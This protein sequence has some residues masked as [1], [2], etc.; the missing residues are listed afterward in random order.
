MLAPSGMLQISSMDRCVL[1]K[2]TLILLHSHFANHIQMRCSTLYNCA[3]HICPANTDKYHYAPWKLNGK[4]RFNLY[5]IDWQFS[6]VTWRYTAGLTKRMKTEVFSSKWLISMSPTL[7]HIHK[8][9]KQGVWIPEASFY[10]Y[11]LKTF[12]DNGTHPLRPTPKKAPA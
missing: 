1:C 9:Q 8:E 3:T 2:L 12:N 11:F 6:P 5:T 10:F 7:K 4:Q